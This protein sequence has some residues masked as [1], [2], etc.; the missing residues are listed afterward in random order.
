MFLFL[1]FLICLALVTFGGVLPH[2][3]LGLL[4]LW[5]VGAASLFVWRWRSGNAVG[6]VFVLGMACSV[7]AAAF[8][9]NSF[10]VGLFAI[11]WAWEASR[12]NPKGTYR[13]VEL[14]I[15]VGVA[16]AL[17]GL[18]QN[19]V[20]PGWIFGY[21]NPWSVTSGTLIN[22]NHFAGLMELLIPLA[23]SF[24]WVRSRENFARA[25][26]YLLAAGVM[27]LALVFS[28][29]RSGIF[30][31]ALMVLC[32][33]VLIRLRESRGGAAAALALGLVAL[34]AAGVIWVGVDVI[35][36]RYGEVLQPGFIGS[37]TRIPIFQDTV[38]MIREN[39]LGVGVGR[40]EDAFRQYQTAHHDLLFDHAHNDYLEMAAEWGIG[41][42]LLFWGLAFAVWG[43]AVREFLRAETLE[44]RALLLGCAGGVLS[45]SIH[46]L[47]DFNLQIP[48]NAMIFF[49]LLGILAALSFP[50]RL[51]SSRKF[52]I[53][54]GYP[55][56]R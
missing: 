42:A 4:L 5:S 3:W 32:L 39:P 11:P 17:L 33:T 15:V 16:E 13:F 30:S 34:V 44:R 19:F 2:A 48:S 23:F 35:T 28:L 45:I 46:S 1:W 20:R 54:R 6:P 37:Q 26:V 40:F 55:N 25:W 21:H 50:D 41:P 10:L 47:T 27:G 36:T 29:S 24:A 31:F 12:R 38:R 53:V 51:E 43:N 7:I 8:F 52:T 18:L 56:P 22:R 14:L 9:P 49:S